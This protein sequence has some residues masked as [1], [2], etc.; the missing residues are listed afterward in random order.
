MKLSQ[1]LLASTFALSI[2]TTSFLVTS[3]ASAKKEKHHHPEHTES[4][5]TT[6]TTSVNTLLEV[7]TSSSCGCSTFVNAI[8]AAGLTQTLSTTTSYTLFIPSDA[9]FAALPPATLAKLLKPE[10]R[11]LLQQILS[12]HVLSGI[13]DS[14]KIKSGKI[15]TYGGQI[16]EIKFKKDKIEIG[17]GKLKKADLKAKNGYIH[18]I[19]TVLIPP[20]LLI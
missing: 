7:A 5:T 1:S 14:K 12:Y 8:Q 4:V 10:N 19:D 3:P 11:V 2:A 18:V 9:A 15:K 20:G 17:K 13:V 6:T 16:L